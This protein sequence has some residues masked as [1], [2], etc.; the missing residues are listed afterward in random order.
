MDNSIVEEITSSFDTYLDKNTD[1]RFDE[2]IK[3]EVIIFLINKKIVNP[4]NLFFYSICR[5]YSYNNNPSND[6]L[7]YVIICK[8]SGVKFIN[9]S[10]INYEGDNI[11]KNMDVYNYFQS[12]NRELS[13]IINRKQNFYYDNNR[14][15]KIIEP[16]IKNKVYLDFACGYGGVID[17]CTNICKN[18]IGIEIMESSLKLLKEKYNYEFYNNIEL[19]KNESVDVISIFQSFE[20]LSD[21]IGYLEKFYNKLKKG[22]RLVIETSNANKALYTLYNNDGYKKFITSLRK[23]IYSEDAITTLL[24][25][26]G[27]K[28]ISVEYQQRYNISNHLGWLSYNKP[29]N[30]II[31]LDNKELNKIYKK[32]LIDKKK[33][34]TLFIVCEK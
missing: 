34:D 20:L 3:N 33:S 32:T 26:I 31:E 18:I 21:H 29:G 24:L 13:D 9:E 10:L 6:L 12:S 19:I 28:N 11:Y 5:E 2:E 14:R 27:F 17:K 4:N 1:K 7:K 22:G 15:F 23:V 16:L 30:D 25:N 8:D